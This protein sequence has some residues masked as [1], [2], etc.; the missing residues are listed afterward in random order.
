[1]SLR[2]FK[3]VQKIRNVMVIYF[4]QPDT[5]GWGDVMSVTI[6]V[7]DA[8]KLLDNLQTTLHPKSASK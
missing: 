7:A 4:T 2:N 1:M 6:P 3:T 5:L 8:Q